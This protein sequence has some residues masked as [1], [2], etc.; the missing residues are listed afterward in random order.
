MA[1]MTPV[2]SPMTPKQWRSNQSG[3]YFI[4][5]GLKKKTKIPGQFM[6][7]SNLFWSHDPLGSF[8]VNSS[9][10]NGRCRLCYNNKL[11]LMIIIIKP[12]FDTLRCFWQISSLWNQHTKIPAAAFPAVIP[13]F[14]LQRMTTDTTGLWE[15]QWLLFSW[16]WPTYGCRPPQLGTAAPLMRWHFGCNFTL[17]GL[18]PWENTT[19]IGF[20]LVLNSTTWA[21]QF[22][23]DN[24]LD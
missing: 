9:L 3:D 11:L 16:N 19:Y 7:F 2:V 18:I 1:R 15:A 22:H 20:E 17:N 12:F 14:F 4:S 13:F 23:N 24:K 5:V 6:L 21:E 8:S 10:L